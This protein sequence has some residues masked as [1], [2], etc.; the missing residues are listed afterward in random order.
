MQEARRET[1]QSCSALR[2]PR[3][4][5]QSTVT[6][7]FTERETEAQGSVRAE[8]RTGASQVQVLVHL[9]DRK[10]NK[11]GSMKTPSTR[12]PPGVWRVAVLHTEPGGT[13]GARQGLGVGP[14]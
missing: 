4:L 6:L 10:P 3:L 12:D 8:E 14:K 9:L 1:D 7:P 5:G 2:N 11:A 13:G